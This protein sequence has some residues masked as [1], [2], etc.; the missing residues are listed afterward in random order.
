MLRD[1]LG[2]FLLIQLLISVNKPLFRY[3]ERF[4]ISIVAN[5]M[6]V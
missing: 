2:Y 5:V 4:G 1:Y 6:V 3:Y